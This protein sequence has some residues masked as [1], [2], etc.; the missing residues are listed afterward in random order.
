MSSL[1]DPIISFELFVPMFWVM[2]PVF[3]IHREDLEFHDSWGLLY[4]SRRPSPQSVEVVCCGSDHG[5]PQHIRCVTM[6]A[7]FTHQERPSP[8]S[9][10]VVCC[11]SNHG[12]PQHIKCFTR[13][14]GAERE[15]ERCGSAGLESEGSK[16]RGR[17]RPMSTR[18][19]V[20]VDSIKRLLYKWDRFCNV[21]VLW[22]RKKVEVHVMLHIVY[23]IFCT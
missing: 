13:R 6:G 9:V 7:F 22:Y 18:G 5:T 15:R 1:I 17:V 8:Q 14:E 20:A 21:I 4:L 19:D 3:S 11:G 10:E 16:S 23:Y 12:T 2:G